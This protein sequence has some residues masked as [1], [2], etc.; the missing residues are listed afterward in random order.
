MSTPAQ[1]PSKI[2]DA[3]ILAAVP[4]AANLRQLLLA[5]GVA[6]Y[7]GNYDVIRERLRLLGVDDPRFARAPRLAESSPVAP[8]DLVR[9]VG[10]SDSYA[11]A[12]RLLGLGEGTAAQRR[13]KRMAQAA[14]LDTSHMLGQASGRGLRR[15]GRAPEPLETVLVS[16]RRV[17]TTNLR[18]RLLREGVLPKAC[19]VCQC[20]EWQ[21]NPIPLELDHINGDRCDNR[22]ENLRLVCPNCHAQTSTYR[23]RNI[24]VPPTPAR[25]RQEPCEPPGAAAGRRLLLVLSPPAPYA[26]AAPP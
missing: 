15:G 18:R 16:G 17:H 1:R 6:A 2:S 10:W 7:G 20:D 14:G 3:A 26:G 9:A 5:L 23:G 22:L 8:K 25:Q 24:G 4:A 21:A 13:V 19:A 12:A 11:Q